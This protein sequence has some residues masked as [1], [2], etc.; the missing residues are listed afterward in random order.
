LS[1]EEIFAEL[2][3]PSPCEE[4][5]PPEGGFA[6]G[7]VDSSGVVNITDGIALLNF[8]FSGGPEPACAD[9]ADADDSGNLNLT[10]AIFIF[11]WLFLGGPAPGDPMPSQNSYLAE[12]CGEDPTEDELDCAA[13]ADVCSAP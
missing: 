12:D 7:D 9:G 10:D 3:S 11:R 8:L 13:L 4:L 6:R 1:E 5:A 2:D